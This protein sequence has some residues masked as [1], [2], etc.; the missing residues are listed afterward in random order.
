MTKKDK[1]GS[2]LTILKEVAGAIASTDNIDSIANL[3]LDLALSY[4]KAQN[5]SILLSNLKNNFVVKAA[6][7]INNE[8][9]PTIKV[10]IGEEICGRI[11]EE[12]KPILVKDIK[13]DER[14]RKKGNGKYKTGS[15]ICCPIIM[16]EK[17]LGVINVAD[18]IDRTPFT[19]DEF[20]LINILACQTAFSLEYADL[21]AELRA[22]TL[23]MD[24]RNK[25]LID[26]DR[27][28]SE[29]VAAMSHEFRTPLNSIKGA[30]Y[31]LKEKRPAEA[32]QKEFINIISDETNKLIDLLDGVLNFSLLEKEKPILNKKVLNF[33]DIVQEISASKI[34][35]NIL[36]RKNISMKVSCPDYLPDIVGEKI[37]LIQAMMHLIEGLARYSISGDSIELKVIGKGPAVEAELFI[38]GRKISET[39]LPFL[40]D[41]RSLWTE[42]DEIR[43][44]LIFYLAKKTIELHKGSIS[45]FNA[46]MGITVQIAFPLSVKEYRDAEINELAS[47]FLSLTAET[48]SLN[49]CSLM[50]SDEL[51]GELTIK[52]AI[53]FDEEIIRKTRVR[54][55]DKIAGWV[56]VEN[57]PLL[58]EDLEDFPEIGK[59]ARC[60]II[61]NP[62]FVSPSLLTA[63]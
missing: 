10:K 9:I 40:F 13:T 21:G 22:K 39:E 63:E 12:R 6:K 3:I 18:K 60:S 56:A 50:L 58:I 35:K 25:A 42:I 54:T 26:A 59:K 45:I 19:E 8:V 52:N 30:V 5:G 28:R 37:R 24:E 38:K 32:E 20:D 16:R 29:F 14:I 48:M 46:P 23:E 4:T 36:A 41:E 61:R 51:T 1:H 57:K 47:L 44:K 49:K 7:G 55:G 15:F 62:S 11:A 43:N 2:N 53:G 27:L 31:Y 34:I 33:R 17:L